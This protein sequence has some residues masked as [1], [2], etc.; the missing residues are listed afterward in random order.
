MKKFIAFYLFPCI[1]NLL[2]DSK[3]PLTDITLPNII[4]ADEAF[5]LSRFMVKPF[6]RNQPLIDQSKAIFNYRLSRA[7]RTT[8]NAFGILSNIFRIFF[9]PINATTEKVFTC[10]Y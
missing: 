2:S 6:P 4:L 9:T 3:L 8:G 1:F 7:R 5:G 10:I